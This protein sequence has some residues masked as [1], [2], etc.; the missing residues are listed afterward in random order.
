MVE[1]I[2]TL[3]SLQNGTK[4]SS[5]E[6][7]NAIGR[8]GFM[9]LLLAQ[10]R[11]QDPNNPLKSHEFAA[12]LAQFTSVEQLFKINENLDRN[13]EL[14]LKLSQSI[15]NSL[16]TTIVGKNLRAVGNQISLE[17][18]LASKVY[19]SLPT[20]ASNVVVNIYD[21][22]D[23]L[24]RR[25]DL[26]LLTTGDHIFNWDGKNNNG[27]VA[28]DGIYTFSVDASNNNGE[29]MQISFFMGGHI[30]GVKFNSDNTTMFLVGTLNI[31]VSDVIMITESDGG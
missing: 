6:D 18:T 9:K 13:L 22:N 17:K 14:D 2:S 26:N 15:G 29:S 20:A 27:E 24:V 21:S 19:I 1:T 4:V 23:T 3:E 10:L 30:T 16:A 28:A 12:Q 8:D 31:N 5:R 25:Q 11:N 7:K